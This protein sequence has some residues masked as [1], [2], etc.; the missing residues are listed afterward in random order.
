MIISHRLQGV[1]HADRIAVLEEGKLTELGAHAAL[2]AEQGPYAE[3]FE[4][5]S[6][7]YVAD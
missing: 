3:L 2:L 4:L 1:V 6:R 7:S 5:Q